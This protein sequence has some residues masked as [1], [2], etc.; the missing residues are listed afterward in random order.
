MRMYV[1]ESLMCYGNGYRH[2]SA[3]VCAD[4]IKQA[5]ELAIAQVEKLSLTETE[6]AELV[7]EL[8]ARRPKIKVNKVHFAWGG[9]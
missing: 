3:S 4:D 7:T 1:W 8:K 6:K 5:R 2:G 9:D